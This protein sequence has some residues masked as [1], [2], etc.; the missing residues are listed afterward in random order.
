MRSPYGDG[1]MVV[2][3]VQDSTGTY[4]LPVPPGLST[5]KEAVAWTYGQ[6]AEN[7]NPVRV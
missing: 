1:H 2:V 5:A 7:F 3:K 4:W 6:S